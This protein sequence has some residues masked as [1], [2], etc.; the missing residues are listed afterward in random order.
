M[1]NIL[2]VSIDNETHNIH[3]VSRIEKQLNDSIIENIANA[4]SF[5]CC[6]QQGELTIIQD[7]QP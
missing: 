3:I 4:M 2:Y 6:P 7:R 5:N 1:L